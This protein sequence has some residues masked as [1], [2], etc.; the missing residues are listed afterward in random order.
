[1]TG[2]AF[3]KEE[4]RG[5]GGRERIEK[6]E[7]GEREEEREKKIEGRDMEERKRRDT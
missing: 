2:A 6:G 1:M 7:R 4:R 5:K 3:R